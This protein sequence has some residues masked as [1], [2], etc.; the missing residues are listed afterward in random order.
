MSLFRITAALM[1]ATLPT[2]LS[3]Q[4]TLSLKLPEQAPANIFESSRTKEALVAQVLLDRSRHSPGVIDGIMGG[5]TARAI[6]AFQRANGMEPTGK[7][8]S[9]LLQKLLSQYSGDIVERYKITSEDVSG[10][11]IDVPDSMVAKAKLDRLAYESPAEAL[12]E[13]FHMAK[14]F[15]EALTPGVDFSKAGTAITVIKINDKPLQADVARIEVDKASS[16]VRA[17]TSDGKLVATYPATVGSSTFPSPSGTMKVKAIA[18]EPKYYF[19]PSGHKWG[20]DK[21]LTIAA[22]PNN[23]VGSTW[24]DLSKDGYG[25]HGSPDPKLIGK[26][27]SHGCVRLTNWDAEELGKAVSQGTVVEFV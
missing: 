8:S 11:F 9:S 22:G 27:A 1:L 17:Y 4:A 26:T 10:P 21:K 23:P 2:A 5:N 16:S 25:I 20:P 13:K 15:I 6:K 18:A 12:A 19:D 7:L 3:A 24:I 14:S